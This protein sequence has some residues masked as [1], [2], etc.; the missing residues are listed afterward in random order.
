MLRPYVFIHASDLSLEGLEHMKCA[1]KDGYPSSR[2][3]LLPGLQFFRILV[4]KHCATCTA[5][6]Y[7]T[8]SPSE[9]AIPDTDMDGQP[10]MSPD[11]A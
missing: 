6:P 1:D 9:D 7:L 4:Y 11:E 8:Q 10:N 5:E 2:K 3:N